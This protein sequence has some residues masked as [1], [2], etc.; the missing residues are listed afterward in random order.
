MWFVGRLPT[1]ISN[2]EP[3]WHGYFLGCCSE[4]NPCLVA[5]SRLFCKSTQ[6]HHSQQTVCAT[7][8]KPCTHVRNVEKRICEVLGA[9]SILTPVHT[10][11]HCREQ[12][13]LTDWWCLKVVSVSANLIVPD[14]MTDTIL[15]TNP[16]YARNI[17][18]NIC[19]L[20]NVC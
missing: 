13:W 7:E 20:L 14:S 12:T 10:W 8:C 6:S 11:D 5:F 2:N 4:P 18:H 17:N 19:C 9:L 3:C 15:Q 1:E 16:Y